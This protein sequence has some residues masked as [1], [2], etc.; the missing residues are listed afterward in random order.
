M[1]WDGTRPNQEIN[2]D[3]DFAGGFTLRS[4]IFSYAKAQDIRS[5]SVDTGAWS[6]LKIPLP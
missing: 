4:W 1:C 5:P 6:I 3:N 2:T